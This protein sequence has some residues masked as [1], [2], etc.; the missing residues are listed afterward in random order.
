MYKKIILRQSLNHHS[1][2]L[3]TEKVKPSN[4]K[5]LRVRLLLII[6]TTLI[7]LSCQQESENQSQRIMPGGTVPSKLYVLDIQPEM[8]WHQRNMLACF[9]GLI[10]RKDTRIYYVETKQDQFWLDYY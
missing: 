6:L 2:S 9:Q 7:A 4:K 10:N 8:N 5:N 3:S 1:K